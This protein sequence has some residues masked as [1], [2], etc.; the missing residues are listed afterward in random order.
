MRIIG[1]A[2]VELYDDVSALVERADILR[3]FDDSNSAVRL[4]MQES[5]RVLALYLVIQQVERLLRLFE[6]FFSTTS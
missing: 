2:S 4:A 1:Y 6:D 5:P 3:P